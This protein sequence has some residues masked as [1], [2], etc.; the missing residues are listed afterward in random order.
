MM[1][2]LTA[3]AELPHAVKVAEDSAI[4]ALLEDSNAA[5][6]FAAGWVSAYTEAM[7]MK[8]CTQ[9]KALSIIRLQETHGDAWAR[10]AAQ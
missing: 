2:K 10:G 8:E 6:A 9:T 5:G 7:R 1:R 3:A 4:D